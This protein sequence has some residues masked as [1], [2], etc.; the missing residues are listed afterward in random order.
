MKAALLRGVS[1][2]EQGC[3]APRR[4]HL[5]WRDP[6]DGE[7]VIEA[8]KSDM[9]ARGAASPIDRFVTIGWRSAAGDNS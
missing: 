3:S 8:R 7:D 9:I 2:V 1:R 5:V 4:T 6:D